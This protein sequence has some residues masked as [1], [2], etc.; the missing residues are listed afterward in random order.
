MSENNDPSPQAPQAP[1]ASA[2]PATPPAATEAPAKR[3]FR[4]RMSGAGARLS[5]TRGLVAATL[6]AL[7]VG[8]FGGAAIHAAVD[9]DHDERGPF[10]RGDHRGDLGRDFGDFR[11]PMGEGERPGPPGDFFPQPPGGVPDQAPPTSTPEDGD[12]SPTPTPSESP[13]ESSSS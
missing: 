1:E 12:S 9:D 3:T 2:T 11:G 7:I 10:F 13:S 4:E 6:A 5:G 8:G